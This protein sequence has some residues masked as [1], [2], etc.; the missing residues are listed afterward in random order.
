M[1]NHHDKAR[2]MARSVLPSTA[3][4]GARRARAQIHRRERARLRS[5]LQPRTTGP[6]R[7]P[8]QSS[9]QAGRFRRWG[10]ESSCRLGGCAARAD[11]SEDDAAPDD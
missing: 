8:S 2:D 9:P 5:E 6:V 7:S 10:L 11:A 1:R 4:K 3:R